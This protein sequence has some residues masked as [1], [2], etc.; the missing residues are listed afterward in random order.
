MTGKEAR[1]LTGLT[2]DG[3]REETVLL[4][5]DQIAARVGIRRVLESAG[6]RV[7]ADVATAAEAL[8][9]AVARRPDVCLLAVHLPGDS[10]LAA[11][12]IREMAPETKIVMLA[13]TPG[14][15]EMFAALRAGAVGYLPTAT[16][17]ERLPHA[18]RGVLRGEAALPRDLTISL[19]RE[20]RERG[21]RRRLT[22]SVSG[23]EVEL[24]SREFEVL[25]HVRRGERTA[26]IA[27]AL[28]ISDITV[29]RHVST[30]LHKL[31]VRD[32]QSAIQ[33]LDRAEQAAAEARASA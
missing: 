26:R 20:F 21:R 4:A 8:Q 7:V 14:E 28:Q 15:E 1:Q 10:I 25:E 11:E 22:F 23:Q 6:L 32:R 3:E 19:I 31:G 27:Q 13:N 9:A 30:T 12:R 18:I 17:A 29:R 24:T 16:S 33:L 5:D 2:D